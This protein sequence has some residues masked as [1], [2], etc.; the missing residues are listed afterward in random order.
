VIDQSEVPGNDLQRDNCVVVKQGVHHV[1]VRGLVLRNCKRAGVMLDRQFRPVLDTQTHDIV[2]EDNEVAGWGGFEQ[3]KPAS[4]MA[5]N[6]AAVQ[7]NYWRET[8]DS[9]RPDRIIIQ[10]NV[11]RD[12]RYSANPW[13]TGSAPR[14]HPMGPQGVLFVKCGSNHVIRYN[15]IYSKNGNYFLDGLGGEEN[16]STAGFP[17]ADSDIN[18]NKIS[19]VYDDGIEAEGGNRNVRIWGNYMDRVF[20]AVANAATAVGPLYVWRNVS[21][22]MANMFQPDA[23]PD[24]ETRGSFIKAGSNSAAANGGRAYYFHNTAL[25]PPPAGGA[26]YGMGSGWGIQ[27]SGGKLYNFVSRNNIWQVHKEV[28]IH[29]QPKYASIS[30]D[31]D[32]GPVDADYDLYNAP[33]WN[34]GRNAQG[35]GWRGVPVYEAG[36]SLKNGSPGH[37]TAQ[38]IPNFNDQYARPDVGAQQSGMPPLLFGINAAT[39]H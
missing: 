16:F 19:E 33:M 1:I 34:A 20:V 12:P 14:K 18:G 17:W 35:H 6:D 3:N 39:A 21:N 13:R 25:Q 2:I 10:R 5:D 28:Q 7:C 31:A 32:R 22:R 26:R 36:F 30:A 23:P 29:G 27:N 37:G 8:D 9:K 38:R 24:E 11:M 4:G 15:E